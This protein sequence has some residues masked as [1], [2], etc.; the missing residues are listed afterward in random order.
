MEREMENYDMKLTYQ[1]Y[2]KKKTEETKT[3]HKQTIKIINK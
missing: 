1:I 2:K 3:N